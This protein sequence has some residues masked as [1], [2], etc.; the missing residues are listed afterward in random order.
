MSFPRHQAAADNGSHSAADDALPTWPIFPPDERSIV[1]EVLRTGRVNYWTGVHAREFENEYARAVGVSRAIALMNGTVALELPLRMWNIGPGDEVVVTPR[2][3]IAS[4]SCVVLQGAEPVFA[5]V[6]RDTGNVTA[7]SI[8]RVLTSRTKAIIPVHL[9]GWPCEMQEIMDLA[10]S[11]RIKVLEDCAQAHGAEVN[12]QPIGSFG[13]AAAFSFCQDKIITT[14]G[15]GGLLVTDDTDVWKRAWAFKD[16]GK[17]YDAVYAASHPPGFRWLHESFGTNWRMT[18]I[19][20]AIGRIQLRKLPQWQAQREANANVLIDAL[21]GLGSIRLPRPRPNARHAYYRLY[22]YVVP[23]FVKS[24]WTRDRLIAEINASG[25]PCF[26]GSCSEV[27][28]EKAFADSGF[29]SSD[30]PVAR[31]LGETSLAF[32]VHPSLSTDHIRQMAAKIR[33]ILIAATR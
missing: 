7:R 30:L 11:R 12:G 5:D 27:Y 19:Q 32:L 18:E 26:S 29:R 1:E 15:E 14:G 28:R 20:A 24:G 23:E 31:E 21:E 10:A 25:V 3:F 16:H 4:I 17:S 33:P 22:A 9:G 8:E 2:T 13:D 6:D